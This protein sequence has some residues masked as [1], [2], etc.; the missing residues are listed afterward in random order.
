MSKKRKIPFTTLQGINKKSKGKK[1]IL[2]GAGSIAE[3]TSRILYGKEIFAI[4]DNAS[5]LWGEVD[6]DIKIS[7][8][9]ILKENNDFF[10][11]ICT[12]SFVE[13]ADQLENFGLVPEE[14]FYV[15]PTLNDL[16]I[17]DELE[18][19]KKKMLFTSGSPKVNNDLYGGGVY[20]LEVNGDE[21]HHKKV[22][23]GNCY[24]LIEF[25]ENF[26]SVDTERGIFEFDKNYEIIRSQKL[27]EGMRAHGVEYS[28]KHKKF[29]IVGSY[30]DGVLILDKE[31]KKI[32]NI[33]ISI[34]K[35]RT[36]TPHHHCND[37]LVVDD[38]IY[39]SMFSMTGNW[40]RDVFDGAIIEYD[41]VTQELVGPVIQNLWMPHNVKFI[42]GSIHVL[43]SLEG[44]L[45]SNNAKVLGEFPAFTRGL[46]HDGVFYFIGQ[47]RN[48]NYSKNLGV[49]KNVSI[50]A[51]VIV[52]DSLTKASRF[53]QLPPKISELHSILLLDNKCS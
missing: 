49:S 11:I 52:F 41:I 51:G 36:G 9:E 35:E 48:R 37:C 20:E 7:S 40:K 3:K 1:V 38:S 6:L 46:D 53:L 39:V 5:N 42:E 23:S 4:V 13:V 21:W 44:Q 12:T 26:I 10:V 33:P 27:P 34:K 19:I 16:R 43:N 30:F 47:S 32:S 8:P 29:F 15:S 31:F 22:I 17:I 25:G 45:L 18:T 50:D 24:G 2:F 28:E 14:D